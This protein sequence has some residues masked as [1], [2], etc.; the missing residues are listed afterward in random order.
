M[1]SLKKLE[2][3]IEGWL[4]PIPH[5]PTTWRKWLSENVWWITLVGVIL[6]ILGLLALLATL[7]AAMSLFGAVSVYSGYYAP[8]VYTGMGLLA[9]L[10]SLA[11][12]AITV[13]IT[14]MA[15]APL[16]LMKAKGWDLLFVAFV[17]GIVSQVVN[18]FINF[19]AVTVI[20]GLVGA[21]I[22][23]AISAYF[24]FEIRSYFKKA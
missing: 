3:T 2:T 12:L 6:S 5:L 8:A 7:L 16:K 14:A 21:A 17:I 18:V 4:K 23:A 24:L 10:V 11:F 15:V 20:S 9:G 1:E 22:G 13:V 19:N